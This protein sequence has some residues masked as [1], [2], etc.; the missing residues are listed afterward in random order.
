MVNRTC[1]AYS[2]LFF[3]R[4]SFQSPQKVVNAASSVR[5]PWET[6]T[7]NET[8]EIVSSNVR[9]RHNQFITSPTV[10]RYF[11]PIAT[12]TLGDNP[13]GVPSTLSFFLIHVHEGSKHSLSYRGLEDHSKENKLSAMVSYVL[14][15]E[16]WHMA[17]SCGETVGKDKC[18]IAVKVS[19]QVCRPFY[20]PDGTFER[21]HLSEC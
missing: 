18:H 3:W 10:I 4:H 21:K 7:R 15:S 13:T 11:P 1:A 9:W 12:K 8:Y 17:L 14:C 5:C 16:F 2:V 6:P 20:P 19:G